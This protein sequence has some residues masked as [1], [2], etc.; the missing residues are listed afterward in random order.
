VIL[1][2]QDWNPQA[3]LQA[4][5]RVH[6]LGQKS[7]VTIYRFVSEG[8]CEER[9]MKFAERKLELSQGILQDHARG[10][11]EED[12][13]GATPGGLG[14]GLTGA[15]MAE[16]VRFGGD[17]REGATDAMYETMCKMDLDDILSKKVHCSCAR[18][19]AYRLCDWVI[20]Y[21]FCMRVVSD[22]TCSACWV[23][24]ETSAGALY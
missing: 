1:F 5:D 7:P 8:T 23:G 16:M 24:F 20:G 22:D 6:R 18:I 21:L 9:I 10:L 15:D 3:D 14:A 17:S 13:D 4:Q 11:L 2:D 19:S 12:K